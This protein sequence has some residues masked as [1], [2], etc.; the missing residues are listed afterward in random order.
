MLQVLYYNQVFR[1]IV[2]NS[3]EVTSLAMQKVG[4]LP[5][6]RDLYQTMAKSR[7]QRSTLSTK[8]LM[9]YVQNKNEIL[10]EDRH[11]DCHEF[12]MWLLNDINDEL[13]K[14]QKA[15]NA[16]Y[17]PREHPTTL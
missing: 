6:I 12:F 4:V 14:K 2:L 10:E 3:T 1:Q 16:N 15:A 8:K 9:T 13:V 7:K 5:Y 17:K 11:Q